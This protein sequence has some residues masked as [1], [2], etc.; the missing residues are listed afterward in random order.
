MV[1]LPYHEAVDTAHH[2]E[3]CCSKAKGSPT[4]FLPY[5]TANAMVRGR[6]YT[7]AL[8]RVRAKQPMDHVVCTPLARVVTWISASSSCCSSAAFTVCG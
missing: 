8:C 7:L 1:A 6:R 5:A 4:H 3:G 2:D